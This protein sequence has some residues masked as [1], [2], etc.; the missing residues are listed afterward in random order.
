MSEHINEER[1]L[2]LANDPVLD[3]YPAEDQHISDCER[4]M[5]RFVELLKI[6]V[7]RGV[8]N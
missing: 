7:Q 2:E 6:N 1:L 8:F 3:A 5:K 4:C